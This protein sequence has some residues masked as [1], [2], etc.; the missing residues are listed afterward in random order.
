MRLWDLTTGEQRHVFE[1]HTGD[2]ND[3]TAMP[4]DRFVV[5]AS[6]DMSLIVWDLV[7]R[8]LL[9]K[10]LGHASIVWSVA[11]SVDGCFVFSASYDKS[12]RAWDI[13]TGDQLCVIQHEWPVTSMAASP[14]GQ[15]LMTGDYD[16]AMHMWDASALPYAPF[17]AGWAPG[18]AG[19]LGPAPE[20]IWPAE[21]VEVAQT[22]MLFGHTGDRFAG[23]PDEVVRHLGEEGIW[24][25]VVEYGVSR[26]DLAAVREGIPAAGGESAS[27]SEGASRDSKRRPRPYTSSCAAGTPQSSRRSDRPYSREPPPSQTAHRP[28]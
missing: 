6:E 11:L 9:R 13:A 16:G 15:F 14:D 3:V 12:A 1:G 22:I 28:A 10:L 7:I 17:E 2:V 5:S 25:M 18:R 19:N 26:K 21:L 8:Q 20:L 24:R 23:L 4:D 27:A